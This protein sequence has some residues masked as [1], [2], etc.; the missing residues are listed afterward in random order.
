VA[1]KLEHEGVAEAADLG[2]RLALG[3]KVGTTLTTTHGEAGKS[4][5]EDLLET[6]ELEDREVH[7][8]VETE[9]TLVRAEGRVELNT[10]TAVDSD[11]AVV[12]LPS[13]TELDDTLGDLDNVESSAVLGVDGEE[14]LDGLGDLGDR[15]RWVR[16]FM[17]RRARGATH[18]LELGLDGEVGHV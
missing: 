18:L 2:V 16:K 15:L 12:T 3:V 11:S 5:L 10:E 17:W 14:G 13:N 4:V 7:G 1:R 6:E 8:G 9:T